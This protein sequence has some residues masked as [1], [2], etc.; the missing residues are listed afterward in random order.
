MLAQIITGAVL[1]VDA[2]MVRVEVDLG[3]GLP[4]MNVVGLPESAAREGRERVTAALANAGFP[5]P[6]RR[7]T[8]NL[9]PA[10]I[11]KSGSSY[12]LPLALGLLAAAGALKPGALDG[13]CVVGELGLDGSVRPVRGVLPIAARCR[14]EGLHTLLCPPANAAEACVVEGVE[15]IAVPSLVAAMRHLR[16]GPRLESARASVVPRGVAAPLAE[17]DF[18]DVKAQETAKRALEIAAAGR[19]NVLMVGPPGSGKSMLARRLPSILPPL[20]YAEA[21]EATKVCSVAGGLRPGQALVTARP[22]RAPHHTVSDAG[23]VGGGNPPRPGEVSLAHTGVLF[24]DEL[25]EYRRASL[26]ALRQPLEDAVVCLGR[27]RISLTYPARFMLLAAMNPCP[28]GYYGTGQARCVCTP[29]Q[30]QRYVGRISG[31]LLDRIDIHIEVPSLAGE[32]L[33]DRR[34]GEPS[35]VIRARVLAARQRQAARF[36]GQRVGTGDGAAAGDVPAA[37][38]DAATD[39]TGDPLGAGEDAGAGRPAASLS[40]NADMGPAELRAHCAIDAA[41][42][43][44]LRSAVRRLGLSARAYHRVLRIAR[45]IADL[46]DADTIDVRHVAEAVQ[47]RSLDRP[48]TRR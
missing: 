44:L 24:L 42:E 8:V 12:D 13:I 5:L 48:R 39:A 21:L 4:C 15:V 33:T 27:A 14:R 11:P 35:S 28:C 47:Y 9:A 17:L 36:R 30:V 20:S 41:S 34:P 23:L 6:P 1:G 38:G 32:R 45:T 40:A 22:F 43:R 3:R 18:A 37:G 2:Y 19:H 25:G 10:D 16:G 46:E 31:P 26:E 29:V 7:I